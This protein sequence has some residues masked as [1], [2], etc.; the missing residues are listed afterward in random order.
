MPALLAWLIPAL[1][2]AAS[3]WYA[4]RQRNQAQ[5]HQD[6]RARMAWEEQE[7]RRLMLGRS[8]MDLLERR[9]EFRDRIPGPLLEWISRPA[10]EFT[11]QSYMPS[12]WG[13]AA[14]GGAQA[15]VGAWQ[16]SNKREGERPPIGDVPDLGQGFGQGFSQG[17]GMGQ[18]FFVRA[19]AKVRASVKVPVSQMAS[20][21]YRTCLVSRRVS[22]GSVPPRNPPARRTSQTRRRAQCL[23]AFL[24]QGTGRRF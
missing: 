7:Q 18:G 12:P 20:S 21:R 3:T 22:K 11:G 10:R 19:S 17:F 15:G 6:D 24:K 1:V 14:I 8:V 2:S 13:A 4:S 23:A 5:G 16:A 9:P